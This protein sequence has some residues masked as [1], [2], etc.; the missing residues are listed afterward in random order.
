MKISLEQVSL[1]GRGRYLIVLI[2]LV[3]ILFVTAGIFLFQSINK[4]YIW[5][6]LVPGQSTAADVTRKLGT[7][8]SSQ[9]QDN[10]KT[11]T[12]PST[13][14]YRNHTVVTS[15]NTLELVKEEVIG[16]ERG[17]LQDYIRKYGKPDF[18]GY[19]PYALGDFKIY[20]FL[21]EGLGVV[22]SPNDG[23]ILQ[24]WYFQPTDLQTFRNSVGKEITEF[25]PNIRD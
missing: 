5:R 10:T 1:A 4:P 8:L 20:I 23:T 18:E 24:L 7:P 21:K 25:P 16:N 6:G 19:G 3:I 14:K 13:N 11:L 12:Y 15:N 9:A 22:A 2:L 17:F